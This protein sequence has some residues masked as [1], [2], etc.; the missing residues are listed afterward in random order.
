MAALRL[1]EAND[2]MTTAQVLGKDT[3]KTSVVE[4]DEDDQ[5]DDK[6]PGLEPGLDQPT[7]V[8]SYEPQPVVVG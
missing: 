8:G 7:A 6:S 4:D 5:N 2:D 3:R 1:V